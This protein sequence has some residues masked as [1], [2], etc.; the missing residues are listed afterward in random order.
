M[1]IERYP[2]KGKE[3]YQ[4]GPASCTTGI[5]FLNKIRGFL[6]IFLVYT[7]I[8]KTTYFI[9]KFNPSGARGWTFLVVFLPFGWLF[10][11]YHYKGSY[12]IISSNMSLRIV[13]VWDIINMLTHIYPKLSDLSELYPQNN[14]SLYES[15][16]IRH[17]LFSLMHRH[18]PKLISC[19]G[20]N[21]K[22][23]PGISRNPCTH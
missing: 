3:N 12:F 4:K 5:E 19:L 9:Q 21:K 14:I 16:Q 10:F 20:Y 23:R 22:T 8:Y 18:I 6:Y 11:Y 13:L 1:I 15:N 7:F 2:T 17:L